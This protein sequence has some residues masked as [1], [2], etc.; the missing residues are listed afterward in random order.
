MTKKPITEYVPSPPT[1]DTPPADRQA[2]LV[3]TREIMR[4]DIP[5]EQFDALMKKLDSIPGFNEMLAERIKRMP[6]PKSAITSKS[7]SP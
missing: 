6:A 2:R 1:T 3:Q 5:E 4:G 7:K